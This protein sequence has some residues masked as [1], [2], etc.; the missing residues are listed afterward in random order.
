MSTLAQIACIC[1]VV[2][3]GHAAQALRDPE[4]FEYR[5]EALASDTYLLRLSTPDLALDTAD[6]RE[7]RM[8]VFARQ[9][10]DWTCRGRFDL[11]DTAALD[12]PGERFSYARQFVF[13]C[14]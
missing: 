4:L 14:R 2:S 13:R 12:W 6:W 3:N 8:R 11:A 10:A 1:G 7:T 9:F 5:Y